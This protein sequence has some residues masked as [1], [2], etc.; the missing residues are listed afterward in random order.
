MARIPE[1]DAVKKP[2]Q[3]QTC[4]DQSDSLAEC[5]ICCAD[6]RRPTL[7]KMRESGTQCAENCARKFDITRMSSPPVCQVR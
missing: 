1:H 7:M 2:K 5:Q 6:P 4:A 3:F